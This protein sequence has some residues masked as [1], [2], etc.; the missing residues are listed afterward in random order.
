MSNA[1]LGYAVFTAVVLMSGTALSQMNSFERRE[2]EKKQAKELEERS[3]KIGE[4][5][6]RMYRRGFNN[7]TPSKEIIKEILEM[8]QNIPM[9][10]RDATSLQDLE[11][12][13]RRSNGLSGTA[14]PSEVA[15]LILRLKRDCPACDVIAPGTQSPPP[16]CPKK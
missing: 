6:S 11:Y 13:L 7:P 4:E 5:W 3:E 15:E 10:N 2:I 9:K 16:G 12:A 8:N 1:K 14:R